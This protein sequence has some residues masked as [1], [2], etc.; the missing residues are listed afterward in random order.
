MKFNAL[1]SQERLQELF[2]YN[3][4]TGAFTYKDTGNRA[5]FKTKKYYAIGVDGEQ[6]YAHRLAWMYVNGEDPEHLQIDHRNKDKRDN[7]I[8]NL[9]KGTN[10]QN[11]YNKGANK[12][13]TSGYK[14]VWWEEKSGLYK[15]RIGVNGKRIFLGGYETGE[16]AHQAYLLAASQI[17]GEFSMGDI[18]QHFKELNKRRQRR[19]S[20][21]KEGYLDKA[22]SNSFSGY[23]GVSKTRN[24]KRWMARITI[25]SKFTTLGYFDTPEEAHEAYKK[26]ALEQNW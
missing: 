6:Y 23:R 2:D 4:E 21:I 10:R 1:P 7:R 22:Q 19:R 9:R 25:D 11:S 5:G 15:A 13:N 14:G 20:E 26:S 3:P 18:K 16:E 8:S 24:G 17:A 12:N